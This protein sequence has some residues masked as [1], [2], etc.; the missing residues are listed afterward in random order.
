MRVPK[1]DRS[2]N[3]LKNND[4]WLCAVCGMCRNECVECGIFP[5]K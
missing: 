5:H 4:M 2:F 1:I 3:S